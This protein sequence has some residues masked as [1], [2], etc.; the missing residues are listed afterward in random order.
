MRVALVMKKASVNRE[1]AQNSLIANSWI[2]QNAILV[3]RN[4][5]L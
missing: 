1:T 4:E 2:I 5:R 3:A